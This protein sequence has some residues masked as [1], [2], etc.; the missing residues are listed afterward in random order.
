MIT[1]RSYQDG[2]EQQLY[3]L[4]Y[5][6]YGDGLGPIANRNMWLKWWDWR[7]KHSYYGMPSLWVAESDGK[8]VG[9]Q[10]VNY[11]KMKVGDEVRLAYNSESSMTHPDFQRRGIFQTL[12]QKSYD[13]MAEKGIVWGYGNPNLNSHFAFVKRL[14]WYDLKYY[15]TFIKPLKVKWGYPLLFPSPFLMSPSNLYLGAGH[16]WKVDRFTPLVDELCAD[17]AKKSRIA[18]VKDAGFL[19]WRYIDHP[20]IKYVV[21]CHWWMGRL[22]GFIVLSISSLKRKMFGNILELTA[23]DDHSGEALLSIALRY[24]REQNV[25]FAF[26]QAAG[27]DWHFNP[28]KRAGFVPIPSRFKPFYFIAREQG[29]KW[30]L[31]KYDDWFVQLGDLDIA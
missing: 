14:G 23:L 6:I 27:A 10:T 28:F 2:D 17:V 20:Y 22:T 16:F 3:D 15:R 21:P 12:C 19:N 9:Q 5:A 26:Y 8:I 11:V 13:E 25:D 30:G 18:F 29:G 1:F 31:D 4:A 7:F 24:F